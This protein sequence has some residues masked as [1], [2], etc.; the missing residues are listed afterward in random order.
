MRKAPCA[1]GEDL[2]YPRGVPEA[3]YGSDCRALRRV[4][5]G[6]TLAGHAG[7]KLLASVRESWPLMAPWGNSL[8]WTS[9]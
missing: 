7:L 4:G 5:Y 6:Q 2:P 8:L 3:G 1:G 9:T